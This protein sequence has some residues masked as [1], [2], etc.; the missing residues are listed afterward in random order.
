MNI[1]KFYLFVGLLLVLAALLAVA[2]VRK[3]TPNHVESVFLEKIDLV[4]SRNELPEEANVKAALDKVMSYVKLDL[5]EN[6]KE[7]DA[8]EDSLMLQLDAVFKTVTQQ[9]VDGNR[10][11]LEFIRHTIRE[12]KAA[13]ARTYYFLAALAALGAFIFLGGKAMN[14][15]RKTKEKLISSAFF[16]TA[17]TS[18][19]IL[20]LIM[21]FLFVE[22]LPIFDKVSV[23][24][25]LFG[26]GWYPTDEDDPEFGILPLI[27]GSFSVTALSSAI[28]IPL[29]V[30]TAIYMA[31]IASTRV[32]EMVKP[33]IELLASLPSVVIGF[34]GMVVVAPFLQDAFGLAT[35]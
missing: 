6:A 14:L 7:L 24:D 23:S 30:M 1:N 18:I 26:S 33:V 5:A 25:F 20:F 34:F 27:A 29:G 3:G 16:V 31:E 28:A 22:G 17:V 2:G 21:I 9:K 15:Q 10:E 8:T 19:L 13:S 35:G 4:E 12:G 32:R 11:P